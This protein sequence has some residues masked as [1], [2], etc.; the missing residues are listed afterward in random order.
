MTQ[1]AFCVGAVASPLLANIALSALDRQYQADWQEMSSYDGKRQDLRRK[2]HPTYR[3]VRYA[4][5]LV[6]MVMGTR[7]Q[8]KALL[9]QLAGRVEA[10]GLTLKAEKTA[11]I[12]IDE[13]FVFL[14]ERSSVAPTDTNHTSIPSSRTRRWP[15]SNAR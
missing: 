8:A 12:H 2:G 9:D 5:D 14:G 13:G 3:L 10:L 6:L 7:A 15:R 1:V 11:I 4:D